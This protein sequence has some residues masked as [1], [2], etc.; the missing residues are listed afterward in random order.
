MALTLSCAADGVIIALKQG[1]AATDA[2]QEL[3]KILRAAHASILGVVTTQPKMMRGFEDYRKSLQHELIP[4]RALPD[5]PA[6]N[7]GALGVRVG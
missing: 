1:R 4:M 6:R 5:E 2:D 7:G 3:M